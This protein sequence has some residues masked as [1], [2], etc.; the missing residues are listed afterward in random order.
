MGKL[1]ELLKSL[2]GGSLTGV[3]SN[4]TGS[5]SNVEMPSQAYGAQDYRSQTYGSQGYR[6]QESKSQFTKKERRT[7]AEIA[8]FSASQAN[9]APVNRPN[10]VA[11]PLNKPQAAGPQQGGAPVKPSFS[12]KKQKI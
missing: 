10:T 1:I 6:S 11:A 3:Q 8:Q 4:A 12:N 5:Q 9:S 7:E 2:L